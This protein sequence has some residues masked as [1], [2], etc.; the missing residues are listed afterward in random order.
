MGDRSLHQDDDTI[1]KTKSALADVDPR[2]FP[3]VH[4]AGEFGTV[5]ASQPDFPPRH[6]VFSGKSGVG[7]GP[8]RSQACLP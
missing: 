6:F 8:E 5:V 1:V 3:K 4:E 2:L 7:V